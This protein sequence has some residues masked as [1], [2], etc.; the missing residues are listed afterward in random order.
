NKRFAIVFQSKAETLSVNESQTE[1]NF[2]YFE[3]ASNTFYV[4]KLN[5]AV[6][7]QLAVINMRGQRVMVL[8]NV[9]KSSL[10]QGI[11]LGQVATGAYVICLRTDTN[12][13]LTKKIVIK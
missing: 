5:A 10:E 4:K 12:Q 8:Q 13:V 7:T 2:M 1:S 6:V 11:Q 3:N 9:E